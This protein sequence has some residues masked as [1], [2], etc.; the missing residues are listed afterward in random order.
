[1]NFYPRFVNQ[2][3]HVSGIFVAHHQE[4]YY[5]YT[6]IRTCCALQLT[7]GQVVE[8]IYGTTPDD[9]VQIY[10]KHVGVH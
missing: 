2:P 4:V 3:L 10:P 9:G 1:M 6:T 8:Y 5:I 7:V